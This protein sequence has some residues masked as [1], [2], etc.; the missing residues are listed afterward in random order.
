MEKIDREFEILSRKFSGNLED[1]RIPGKVAFTGYLLISG[2]TIAD[3]NRSAAD[4]LGCDPVDILGKPME[5]FIFLS[6]QELKMDIQG[7]DAVQD[8]RRGLRDC[9]G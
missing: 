2:N 6:G 5:D 4:L 9:S 1:R 7:S 8:R 3:C